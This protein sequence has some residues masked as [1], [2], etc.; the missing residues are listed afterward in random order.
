[1]HTG[2]RPDPEPERG[3]QRLEAGARRVHVGGVGAVAGARG[4]IA[5]RHEAEQVVGVPVVEQPAL[6]HVADQ[7]LTRQRRSAKQRAQRRLHRLPGLDQ[8]GG[9]VLGMAAGI[10]AGDQR[11]RRVE[12]GGGGAVVRGRHRSPLSARGRPS[13]W[14]RRSRASRNREPGVPVSGRF[15]GARRR[16]CRG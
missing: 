11:A 3:L 8:V 6:P 2:E 5:R 12:R 13:P 4:T 14:R 10:Q 9:D 16:R 7:R 15:A 1:V